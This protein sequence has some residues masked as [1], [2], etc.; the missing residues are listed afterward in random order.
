MRGDHGS[1]IQS[2]NGSPGNR[3]ICC[4][5][6]NG[7]WGMGIL[8]QRELEQGHVFAH[9]A[10]VAVWSRWSL[11]L[12]VNWAGVHSVG[13]FL[14]TPGPQKLAYFSVWCWRTRFCGS[15]SVAGGLASGAQTHRLGSE[16]HSAAGLLWEWSLDLECGRLHGRQFVSMQGWGNS[17]C[18]SGKNGRYYSGKRCPLWSMQ[19]TEAHTSASRLFLAVSLYMKMLI[20]PVCRVLFHSTVLL[21]ILKW[22][23][24]YVTAVLVYE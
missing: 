7:M 22:A 3:I 24:E 6:D 10:T 5:V 19:V 2:D 23:S 18:G 9:M 14:L 13:A 15:S 17:S 16:A 11:V 12:C 1:K 4:W 21:Q 8:K 20:K